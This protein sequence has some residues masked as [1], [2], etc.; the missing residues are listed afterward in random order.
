[1]MEGQHATKKTRWHVYAALALFI[2]VVV[3]VATQIWIG[4]PKLSA[5]RFIAAL[6]KQQINDATGMLADP[7]AIE[8]DANGTIT[9]KGTD[10]SS[11]KVGNDEL[12]LIALVVPDAQSRNGAGDYI[13]G[14]YRFQL[15]TSGPA[16]LNGDRAPT[17]V[18]CIANGSRITVA[19]VKH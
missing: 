6:S 17:E 7:T 16:V 1:M 5:E 10:G 11:A 3:G 18:Y 12:P 2:V 14:R 13:A 9:I 4:R 8:S 15:A 19:S